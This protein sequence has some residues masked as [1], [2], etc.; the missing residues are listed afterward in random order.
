[1]MRQKCSVDLKYCETELGIFLRIPWKSVVEFHRWPE[2]GERKEEIFSY[3]DKTWQHFLFLYPFDAPWKFSH[4]SNHLRSLICTLPRRTRHILR[5][6]LN[7]FRRKT[8]SDIIVT[9]TIRSICNTF[10]FLRWKKN[11]KQPR[12]VD[13]YMSK[14]YSIRITIPMD[15]QWSSQRRK[16]NILLQNRRMEQRFENE[17]APFW[18]RIEI[19][20]I[21]D[22]RKYSPRLVKQSS[23]NELFW[24]MRFELMEY[25]CWGEYTPTLFIKFR[26]QS[27][28]IMHFRD[29]SRQIRSSIRKEKELKPLTIHSR[30]KREIQMCGK[31]TQTPTDT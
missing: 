25:S 24:L 20:T 2:L 21:E 30:Q 5:E 13:E 4:P 6:H 14:Q 22:S 28:R 12:H 7:L 9:D 11:R 3:P 17:E 8:I 26:T 27:T 15:I 16:G 29:E 1:M 23:K 10:L 31:G 18:K 19:S